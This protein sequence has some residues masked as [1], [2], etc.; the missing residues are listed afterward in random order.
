MAELSNLS[1]ANKIRRLRRLTSRRGV[2]PKLLVGSILKLWCQHD[3]PGL[4]PA[5]IGFSSELMAD[6]AVVEFT[7]ILRSLDFLAGTYWLSTAFAM[8]SSPSLR[9]ELAMFFTPPSLT[10][11]LLD[12]LATQ[13]VDFSQQTFIDPACGGA[14]FLA[15]IAIRMRDALKAKGF[16]STTLLKHIEKRVSG[17]D[18]NPGLCALSRHFLAMAL[19]EEITASGYVP[20]FKVRSGNSLAALAGAGLRYDV[21]VCNPPYRKV[22]AGEL[23]KLKTKYSD[24][25]GA[26][27]NLYGIFIALCVRLLKR[28]G[29]A[30]LVT[31]TSFL[32]GK[33]F[34]RLRSHLLQK[35]Y[36]AHI[37]MV[38]DRVGVFVDV[39][40]ET[41]L[42]VLKSR[43][44]PEREREAVKVSVV[45]SAG[46]YE[47]VGACVISK[48]GA[49]W[50]IPR[51]P[52][53]VGILQ[54][55]ARS[56][57]RIA[58]YGYRIRIGTYV[59]NRDK[60][61][62]YE[63]LAQVR[64]AKANTA[65]PLIWSSNIAPNG[66]LA[67]DGAAMSGDEHRFVDLGA[68]DHA[69]AVTKPALVLQ[70]VT[71][72][73]QPRRLV[74]AP[75]PQ[76]IYTEYGGFVGEN[77]IVVLEQSVERPGLTPTQMARLMS[78]RQ[79][80]RTFRCISGATNVSVFELEQLALP[81]PA[82]LRQELHLGRSMEESIQLVMNEV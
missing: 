31:P 60:R 34:S 8:H 30:A 25:L 21:V 13:G 37:G 55:A 46:E 50:S 35:S 9:A 70:R 36:V 11:G 42:T 27:P 43:N 20:S 4:P 7:K 24:V 3:Y 62:R 17:M 79:V 76:A 78:S 58:D 39:E 29:T 19:H 68:R 32:S 45:S 81:N 15:P 48:D 33:N 75:V 61:P 64:K 5:R 77:H 72:N 67:F 80:E 65:M 47:D 56:R 22:S 6:P 40:Q 54:T 23:K 82:R 74:A 38:S 69:S 52:E 16:S 73:D 49:A 14:A 51:A 2:T 10:K 57:F 71:S 63:N 12:D 26:Q 66:T 53:D 28:E 18:R 44:G 41:A 1:I 59:W